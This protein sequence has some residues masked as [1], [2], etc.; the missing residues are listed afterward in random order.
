LR[1]AL[2]TDT[3]HHKRWELDKREEQQFWILLQLH[4]GHVANRCI[5]IG[6]TLINVLPALSHLVDEQLNNINANVRPLVTIYHDQAIDLSW[7]DLQTAKNRLH[8]P[9]IIRTHPFGATL[10]LQRFVEISI[11]R[12]KICKEAQ[13]YGNLQ[14]WIPYVVDKLN[15]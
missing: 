7:S 14:D 15:A 9:A 13:I 12:A 10:W 1:L 5:L 6:E 3:E 4:R 11:A 8:G 2:D